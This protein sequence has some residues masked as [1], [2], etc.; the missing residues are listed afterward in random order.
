P[1]L[2]GEGDHR[3]ELDHCL[4]PSPLEGEGW[5]EGR[6]A[7]LSCIPSGSLSGRQSD[8]GCPVWLFE[9]SEFQTGRFDCL[10]RRYRRSRR[11][12]GYASLDTFLSYNK[13]VS[14]LS[15]RDRTLAVSEPEAKYQP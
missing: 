9:R 14:R 2:E 4:S 15:G 11:D 12:G 8:R 6:T 7:K 10:E 13:K 5:G 1:P 3:T